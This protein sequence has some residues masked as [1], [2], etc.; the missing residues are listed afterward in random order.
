MR[1]FLSHF[2][3]FVRRIEP[4]SH[5]CFQVNQKVER[6]SLRPHRSRCRVPLELD[7]LNLQILN[8]YQPKIGQ[9]TATNLI[10]GLALLVAHLAA[11]HLIMDKH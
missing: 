9:L 6:L 7:V 3:R 2:L 8:D 4:N 5:F 11:T 1:S 10:N